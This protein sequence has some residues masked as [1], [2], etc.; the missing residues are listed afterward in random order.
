MNKETVRDSLAAA[1]DLVLSGAAHEIEDDEDL[2]RALCQLEEP[3][4]AP[5]WSSGLPRVY[6]DQEGRR[7]SVSVVVEEVLVPSSPPY[8]PGGPALPPVPD[9][10]GDE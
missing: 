4:D 7:W 5:E 8:A 6:V 1:L 2:E 3:E 9:H 10:G